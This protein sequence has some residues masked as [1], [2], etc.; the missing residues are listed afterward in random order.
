MKMNVKMPGYTQATLSL[1]LVLL[2]SLAA[3]AS[4]AAPDAGQTSREL[5]KQQEPNNKLN[6]PNA[7]KPLH[8]EGNKTSKKSTADVRFTVKAIQVTGSRVYTAAFLEAMVADLIGHEQS[9]AELEAGAERITAY[10]HADYYAVA[11]AYLPPQQI[12]DGLV[13]INV[14]EGLVGARLVTNKSRISDSRV[15]GYLS[16]IKNGEVLHSKSIDRALLLLS[17][18]PGVGIARGSLQPGASV[19][20][21]DLVV[22]VATSAP[23]DGKV[24]LDNYGNRFTGENRLGAALAV[25]SPF[26]LGD[27]ISLRALTSDQSLTYARFAYQLPLGNSGLRAGAAFS[28]TRYKLGKEFSGLQASG[29]ANSG[30]LFAI[31]P[32]LRG[33]VSN[34]SGTLTLEN[35]NLTDKISTF[36]TST[37]KNVQLIS[38]GLA[39]NRQD[40]LGGAAV[41]SFDLSLVSGRLSMDAISLAADSASAK[42]NGA[43]TRLAYNL[44]RLQRLTDSNMLSLALSGQQA[45]KNLNSSE[46]FSLGGANGVRAYPQGEGVG[47]QGWLANVELRHQF[48]QSVQ[49]VLFY[50]AGA[51]D[52]NRNPFAAGE[53]TRKLSGA[54]V[55]ANAMLAGVQIKA[56]LAWR[57]SGGQPTAE[58]ATVK[59]NPRLW[60]QLSKQF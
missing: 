54:G 33:Q 56:Y 2:F 14:L 41:S 3:Q 19:G 46:Q 31:Y 34:L 59:R 15:D 11:R 28:D 57:T 37:D 1:F 4:Q 50:D 10:Y 40:A 23:Y 48:A 13:V 36:N 20:T 8:I 17:D 55:G 60:L 49:G 18:M 26:K 9:L 16:G 7:T 27:Q 32:L 58:P 21:S 22:E 45:N 6:A 51:V 43:F 29:A 47:D 52:I 5:Q 35:K 44:S 38:L 30:S 42:S 39:G 25:N 53:N 12:K 24:E